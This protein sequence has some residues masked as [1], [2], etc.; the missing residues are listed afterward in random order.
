MVLSHE[1]SGTHFL[2]NSLAKCYGYMASPW[3]NVDF[4][5]GLNFYAPQSFTTFLSQ[6]RRHN[7]ANIAKSHHTISFFEGQLEAILSE[8]HI[9][10]VYRDPRDVMVSFWKFIQKLPWYEGPKTATCSD[11]LRAEPAGQMMRYQYRQEKS[12]LHRWVTH[13]DGWT[14]CPPAGLAGRVTCVRFQDLALD[15]ENLM[16]SFTLIFGES[17]ISLEKPALHENSI[18]PNTGAVGTYKE[19][20]TAADLRLVQ[21]IAGP[22]MER[23]GFNDGSV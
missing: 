12:M 10:Y 16:Q 6:F 14:Q 8:F 3:V 11:F 9:F 18:L 15:Y 5:H 7:L 23:L 20:L 4:E 21:E 17:P 22:T 2:M 13:V 1:R 19:Q